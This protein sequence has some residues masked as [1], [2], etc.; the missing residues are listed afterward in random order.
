M[1]ALCRRSAG[2][3]SG[4]SARLRRAAAAVAAAPATAPAAPVSGAASVAAAASE[5]DVRWGATQVPPPAS[6]SLTP[7]EADALSFELAPSVARWRAWTAPAPGSLRLSDVVNDAA[8]AVRRDGPSYWAHHL[9]RTLFFATNGVAALALQGRLGE[10]PA[11]RLLAPA[12]G[13]AE[14]S[15]SLAERLGPAARLVA[16]A[17]ATYDQDGDNVASGLY[18]T[19][20]MRGGGGQATQHGRGPAARRSEC[21]ACAAA[22]LWVERAAAPLMSPQALQ[23]SA[24]PAPP[25]QDV[26]LGHRQYGPAFIAERCARFV[27]EADATLKRRSRGTPDDVWLKSSSSLYP[28]YYLKA[29]N[30][31]DARGGLCVEAPL[32]LTPPA[33]RLPPS[34]TRSRGT[35]RRMGGCHPTRPRCTTR[36]RRRS[37]S[38]VRTRCSAAAGWPC[39]RA[40]CAAPRLAMRW[41]RSARPACSTSP[42]AR[43]GCS[44]SCATRSPTPRRAQPLPRLSGGA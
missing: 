31:V 9:A 12:D 44:A 22:G 17:L 41:T 5:T 24:P 37:S 4:L 28:E 35:T 21:A 11:T 40:T 3:A 8:E 7:A 25:R 42:A 36:P 20:W 32:P 33:L 43:G 27:R 14:A 26:S 23:L 38:G 15:L 19:P 2:R 13:P 39:W 30:G 6:A 34:A 18:T 16:E 29:R 1:R 10:H